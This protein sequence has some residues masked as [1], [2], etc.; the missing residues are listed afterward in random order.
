MI[1]FSPDVMVAMIWATGV[2]V[3]MRSDSPLEIGGMRDTA[4]GMNG[5]R[6]TSGW[7]RMYFSWAANVLGRAAIASGS[8]RT[9]FRDGVSRSFA[10]T[11][12]SWVCFEV[13]NW[14]SCQAAPL[15]SEALFI[16]MPNGWTS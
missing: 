5:S 8:C 14:M 13:M 16:Q 10:L 9:E 3:V 15:C 4:S 11:A 6:V 12:A 1:V 7:A 2:L